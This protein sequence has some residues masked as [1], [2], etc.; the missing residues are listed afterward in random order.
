M[1]KTARIPVVCLLDSLRFGSVTYP[2]PSGPKL[3]IFVSTLPGFV[4]TLVSPDSTLRRI[5][6]QLSLLDTVLF[7]C[8]L[9]LFANDSRLAAQALYLDSTTSPA[10]PSLSKLGADVS[11]PSKPLITTHHFARLPDWALFLKWCVFMTYFCAV[12]TWL[13]EVRF[14]L[15][16]FLWFYLAQSLRFDKL[17]P[18]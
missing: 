5:Q 18:R 13:R 8:S 4:L 16:C 11:C 14:F 12:L 7:S 1:N 6:T 3:T 2:Y 15:C 10:E 9:F 17:R